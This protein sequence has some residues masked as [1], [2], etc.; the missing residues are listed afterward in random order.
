MKPI[1]SATGEAMLDLASALVAKA[2]PTASVSQP[3]FQAVLA[4]ALQGT[5]TTPAVSQAAAPTPDAA[6]AS[7]PDSGTPTLEVS[8]SGASVPAGNPAEASGGLR[9][10]VSVPAPQALATSPVL[11]AAA[12]LELAGDRGSLPALIDVA[13]L[14][15]R[16][17][18]I[19][20]DRMPS[21]GAPAR[22]VAVPTAFAAASMSI[23]QTGRFPEGD[24]LAAKKPVVRAVT[25]DVEEGS[26]AA[27]AEEQGSTPTLLSLA[28]VAAGL[29]PGN[30]IPA[31]AV[32]G[33]SDEGQQTAE[34]QKPSNSTASTPTIRSAFASGLRTTASGPAA[35]SPV[36]QPDATAA[37]DAETPVEARPTSLAASLEVELELGAGR[38][39]ARS[40]QS[41]DLGDPTRLDP[42][43]VAG[44]AKSALAANAARAAAPQ[45]ERPAAQALGGRAEPT[46]VAAAPNEVR[47]NQPDGARRPTGE[48]A[49][50]PAADDAAR[51]ARRPF[52]SERDATVSRAG[53]ESAT[54]ATPPGL[55]VEGASLRTSGPHDAEGGANTL[56]ASR[57]AEPQE[58]QPQPTDRVTV[59]LPDEA[60]GGRIQIA[61]RGDVVHAR[62]VGGDQAMAA[63]LE[64]GLGELHVALAQQGFQ[65]T[66]VR[67]D[68]PPSIDKGWATPAAAASGGGA[69][70]HDSETPERRERDRAQQDPHSDPRQQRDGRSQQRARRERER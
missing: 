64:S 6:V 25:P 1:G 40:S 8:I 14:T 28:V 12:G 41:G 19:A 44:D 17:A 13:R 4:S 54:P 46:K 30:R 52:A 50:K 58:P 49:A 39:D 51:A 37:K 24:A 61:V 23:R 15:M 27:G 42:N 68:A 21:R 9:V 34:R 7:A 5:A 16:P 67:V 26:D 33:E 11:P 32:P 36:H 57:T 38:R 56:G 53:A 31:S 47:V 18:T 65:E 62:I 29:A 59:H 35:A 55:G 20:V 43:S 60:G 70:Q 2:E 63:R 3:S 22:R 45:R 66:H 48:G 69:K 10:E